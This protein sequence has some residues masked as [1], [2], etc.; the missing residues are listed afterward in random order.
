MSRALWSPYDEM[1]DLYAQHAEDS[2]YNA[3]YDRP[4]VLA[5]VGDV[6]GM[7]V[8]D[9]ACGPGIYAAALLD[10]GAEVVGFD[11]S[12]AMVDLARGRVGERAHID[13]ARLDEPLPYADVAFDKC[14]CALAIHYVDD[15]PAAFRELNRVLRPGGALVVSTQHPTA[16]WLRKGGSY[17]DQVL[18]TDRWEGP[19]GGQRVRFWREPLSELCAAAI[20]A[21]FVIDLLVE[22]RP[23]QS[24]RTRYP[25]DYDKLNREP[26]FLLL[27]LLK[28]AS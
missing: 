7:R 10:G 26:G 3:H 8:L 9:A 11:A 1:G 15:R 18:E 28:L 6:R 23:A 21:G 20:G 25:E 22:P 16:D 19:R 27:R 2:S 12:R 5:A 4:A 13:L 24:M 17:F 14:V